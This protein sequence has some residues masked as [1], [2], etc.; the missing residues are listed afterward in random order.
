MDLIKV[1]DPTYIGPWYNKKTYM[2]GINIRYIC[3]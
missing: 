3:K 1:Y 2:E